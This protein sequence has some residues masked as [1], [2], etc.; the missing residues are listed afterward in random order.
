MTTLNIKDIFA[1]PLF[2]PKEE[3]NVKDIDLKT[4]GNSKTIEIPEPP[5]PVSIK[6]EKT[7]RLPDGTSTTT[8]SINIDH[9]F[10]STAEL[11]DVLDAIGYEDKKSIFGR[12]SNRVKTTFKGSHNVRFAK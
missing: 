1:S 10:T 9:S 5:K 3:Y 8:Y 6:I 2:K 12:I 7:K 4:I 11:K